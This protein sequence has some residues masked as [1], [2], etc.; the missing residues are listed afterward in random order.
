VLGRL[1]LPL[2]TVAQ[3]RLMSLLAEDGLFAPRQILGALVE[4]PVGLPDAVRRQVEDLAELHPSRS[5][6]NEAERLLA[7][8]DLPSAQDAFEDPA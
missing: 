2:A 8:Q 7:Q 6:R 3:N 5:V 1:D 4:G